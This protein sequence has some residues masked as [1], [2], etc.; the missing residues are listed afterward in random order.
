MYDTVGDRPVHGFGR[1]KPYSHG[2]R[3]TQ[4]F[5]AVLE[6]CNVADADFPRFQVVLCH[7]LF[8]HILF[9]LRQDNAVC[10]EAV[11]YYAE[12]RLY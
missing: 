7:N 2:G 5:V 1:V 9:V 8:D 11:D 3:P 10:G 12:S 6:P 4:G